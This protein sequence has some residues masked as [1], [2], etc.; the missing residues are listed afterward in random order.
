MAMAIMTHP[1]EYLRAIEAMDPTLLVT[2]EAD[3]AKL[4]SEMHGKKRTARRE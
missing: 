1:P 2:L 3:M 4:R